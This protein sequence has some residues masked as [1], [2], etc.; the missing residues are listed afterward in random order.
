M[1]SEIFETWKKILRLILKIT[2]RKKI[3]MKISPFLKFM[4][5]SNVPTGNIHNLEKNISQ[6]NALFSIIVKLRHYFTCETNSISVS[7]QQ[8]RQWITRR[9]ELM[10]SDNSYDRWRQITPHLSSQWERAKTTCWQQSNV[11]APLFQ[12]NDIP[13]RM[14][15]I[16]YYKRAQVDG[17]GG[18]R[19]DTCQ[20]SD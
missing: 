7:R 8:R 14:K 1:K 6:K 19:R 16:H 9:T 11:R 12:F 3:I 4:Y 15:D 17:D 10:K 18:F 20:V 5:S 2:S 13:T